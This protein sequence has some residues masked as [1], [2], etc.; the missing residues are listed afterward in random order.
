MSDLVIETYTNGVLVG[1][2]TVQ[3]PDPTPEMVNR[4]AIVE[5][6]VAALASN[7]AYLALPSPTQAQ[8]VAQVAALT[9]QVNGLARLLLQRLDSAD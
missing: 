8:A 6:A 2:R 4:A 1:S 5:Q 7:A 9:R 3:V